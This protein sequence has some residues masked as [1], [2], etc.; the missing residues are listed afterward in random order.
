V[1]NSPTLGSGG[2]KEG[3]GTATSSRSVMGAC[4]SGSSRHPPARY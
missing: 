3:S 2:R 1:T 4:P